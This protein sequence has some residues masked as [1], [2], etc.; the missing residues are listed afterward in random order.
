MNVR[1]STRATSLGSDAHQNEF[2][3]FAG[4]RRRNVPAST[5]RSVIRV[6]SSGEPSHHSI[7]SGVVS[8]ATSRIHS[9][10]RACLVG[11]VSASAPGIAEIV[12]QHRLLVA[13]DRK[14]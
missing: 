6:H 1:S 8:S 4:S 12:M 5:R 13:V 14:C 2:G 11:A 7:R 9:S 3:F 10:S